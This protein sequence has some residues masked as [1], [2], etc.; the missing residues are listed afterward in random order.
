MIFSG[1]EAKE[2]FR[3]SFFSFIS[4]NPILLPYRFVVLESIQSY[5]KATVDTILKV[6]EEPYPQ[7]K[8]F[9]TASLISP[10]VPAVQSRF[11]RFRT[12]GL[13]P[14]QLAQIFRITPKLSPFSKSIA[15]SGFSGVLPIQ[16]FVRYQF[17]HYFHQLFIALDILEVENHVSTLQDRFK[18]DPRESY[19]VL[20]LRFIQYYIHRVFSLAMEKGEENF[21]LQFRKVLHQVLP[22]FEF[23]LVYPHASFVVNLQNQLIQFFSSIKILLLALNISLAI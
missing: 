8:I 20:W 13:S 19:S 16:S 7:L 15:I 3:E 5:D 17:E 14:E 18:D 4:H 21:I 9:A 12:S 10:L 22:S 1:R 2:D 11:R 23:A 6:L